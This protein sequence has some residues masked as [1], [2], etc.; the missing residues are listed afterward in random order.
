ML[1]V[2]SKL[3]CLSHTLRVHAQA[4]QENVVMTNLLARKYPAP[5]SKW[6]ARP[7]LHRASPLPQISRL[8]AVNGRSRGQ[9]I[10]SA[11]GTP[12][13]TFHHAATAVLPS[14]MLHLGNGTGGYGP[15]MVS[16]SMAPGLASSAAGNIYTMPQVRGGSFCEETPR[17]CANGISWFSFLRFMLQRRLEF[18]D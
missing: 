11:K 2:A 15:M 13:Q 18:G 14:N 8:L 12:V 3:F 17:A 7:P 5:H 16:Q 1:K 10:S 9:I 4:Q 6:P